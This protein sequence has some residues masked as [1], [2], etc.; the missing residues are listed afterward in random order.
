M[1]NDAVNPDDLVIDPNSADVDD[2]RPTRFSCREGAKVFAMVAM[3]RDQTDKGTPF[4]DFR[5]VAVK[6]LRPPSSGPYDSSERYRDRE[7]DVGLT[8]RLRFHGTPAGV[9]RLGNFAKATGYDKPIRFSPYGADGK[10]DPKGENDD[11]FEVVKHAAYFVGKVEVNV[12][13]DGKREYAE[14]TDWKPYRGEVDPAWEATIDAALAEWDRLEKERA[15]KAARG[16]GKGGGGK[17]GK[18][19]ADQQQDWGF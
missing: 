7:N 4:A 5:M 14:I 11:V 6:D 15:A 12:S 19:K 9:R 10:P 3:S 2:L 1:S 16:G 8:A 13:T 17:G 18:G